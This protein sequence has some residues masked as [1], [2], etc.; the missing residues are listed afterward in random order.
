MYWFT[1]YNNRIATGDFQYYATLLYSQKI[2]KAKQGKDQNDPIKI[3]DYQQNKYEI[4][5]L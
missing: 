1:S 3:P 5:T 4:K 2:L